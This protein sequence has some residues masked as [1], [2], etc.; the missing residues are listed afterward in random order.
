MIRST[1]VQIYIRFLFC[2]PEHKPRDLETLPLAVPQ[3]DS[4]QP[5]HEATA[6][7]ATA[8]GMMGDPLTQVVALSRG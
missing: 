3:R 1:S 7:Q 4:S 6:R 5:S 8:L 2:H